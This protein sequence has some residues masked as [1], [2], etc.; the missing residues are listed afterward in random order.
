MYPS[1][2][3]LVDQCSKEVS[4]KSPKRS[5]LEQPPR[6]MVNTRYLAPNASC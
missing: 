5:F 4:L 1:P 2:K 3:G 6:P